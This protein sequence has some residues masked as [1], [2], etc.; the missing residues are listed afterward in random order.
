ML[1]RKVTFVCSYINT[2]RLNALRKEGRMF[3]NHRGIS[4]NLWALEGLE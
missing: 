4:S 1:Y 3:D 2:K